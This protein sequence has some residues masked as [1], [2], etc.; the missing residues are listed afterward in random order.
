MMLLSIVV[1]AIAR[2]CLMQSIDAAVIVVVDVVLSFS[3]SSNENSLVP[4]YL[5]L[6]RAMSIFIA[7][8][9]PAV[10]ATLR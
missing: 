5:Y 3:G 10:R 6:I 9:V 1:I 2:L 7:V 4:Y 8:V